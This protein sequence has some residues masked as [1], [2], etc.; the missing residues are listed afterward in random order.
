[1]AHLSKS[2]PAL[3][4]APAADGEVAEH[5]AKRQA[6]GRKASA[7][8]VQPIHKMTSGNPNVMTAMHLRLPH[9][10]R[11]AS[12]FNDLEA[13]LSSPEALGALHDIDNSNVV[14]QPQ[15]WS[16]AYLAVQMILVAVA[17]PDGYK[18]T[19]FEVV[20]HGLTP[21]D[22]S[23]TVGAY[24]N[25]RNHELAHTEPHQRLYAAIFADLHASFQPAKE[26]VKGRLTV[27]DSDGNVHEINSPAL[28]RKIFGINDKPK[29]AAAVDSDGNVVA[30]KPKAPAKKRTAAA[31]DAQDNADPAD[32]FAQSAVPRA[33]AKRSAK[34]KASAKAAAAAAAAPSPS[35]LSY[36][37]PSKK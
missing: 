13:K 22:Y 4:S 11:G 14:V 28:R 2:E 37:T 3:A 15:S 21:N 7:E 32:P 25:K 24:A 29:Q 18:K 8:H 12:N 34:A 31:V 16:S 20:T 17:D 5:A 23:N 1:M 10:T 33:P 9:A 27:T 36:P 19:V 6:G 30:S 35:P 26:A